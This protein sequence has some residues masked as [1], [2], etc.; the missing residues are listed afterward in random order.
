MNDLVLSAIARMKPPAEMKIICID[1]TNKCDLACS[2]CTRLLEN[3]DHHWDMTPENFRDALRSLK[4]YPGIIA[5]IGGNPCMHPNFE[6]L[7]QIFTEEIPD[8]SRRGLWTNNF[9]KHQDISKKT[10]GVFNLNSHG[11][12]RGTLSLAPFKDISW[13]HEGNSEHAPLLTAV[14]DFYPE[15]EMWE[16]ISKCDINQNWSATIIQN[17]GKLRCYF[18]EVA[19]S[20]DLARGEDHGIPATPGWW[21][22][23]I[24]GFTEQIHQFCP[25][26]GVPA[27]FSGPLDC[28]EIDM[29]SETN[30]TIAEKSLQKKR[31]IIEIKT[32][33][34]L[35]K[36]SHHV[37]DYSK[38][39]QSLRKAKLKRAKD[40]LL[41]I[42]GL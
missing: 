32:I 40:R 4:D 26:C 24:E 22:T 23:K 17:N 8:K 9:F 3:Q 42:L 11:N 30:K 10:F 15:A 38:N 39:L 18:C 5:M 37:T 14:K 25:S 6:R 1:V 12:K 2:N 34:Q 27:K 16:R 21:K 36:S 20:F 13:Y 29:Y 41:S 35:K 31:K 7:C 28:E 33:D 19:A